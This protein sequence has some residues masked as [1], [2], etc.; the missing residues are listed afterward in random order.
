VRDAGVQAV[1]QAL[2]GVTQDPR[3]LDRLAGLCGDDSAAGGVAFDKA[4][5]ELTK[6]LGVGRV[7][8]KEIRKKALAAGGVARMA[9]RRQ[10]QA[11]GRVMIE[12]HPDQ[13]DQ[14][15]AEVRASLGRFDPPRVFRLGDV[16][17]VVQDSVDLA[18]QLAW[19]KRVVPAA[20][21]R[22]LDGVLLR[23]EIARVAM[24]YDVVRDRAVTPPGDIADNV[25]RTALEVPVPELVGLLSCPVLRRDGSIHWSRGYDTVT[26]VYVTEDFT[27]LQALVPEQ[28]TEKDARVSMAA[29]VAPFSEVPFA[30]GFG[31]SVL[32]AHILTLLIRHLVQVVVGF[33][34][35]AGAAGAGKGLV[36][37]AA[38]RI[39]LG[40]EPLLM[41]ALTGGGQSADEETRK[42]LF[43]C[44]L[45]GR[46]DVVIDN[47]LRGS[48]FGSP[49]LDALF[50][51]VEMSD[52]YLGMSRMAALPNR[53]VISFTGNN[54]RLV[55]DLGRRVLVAHIDPKCPNPEDRSGFAIPDLPAYLLAHRGTL[56]AHALTVMR[57]HLQ[58]NRP[59]DAGGGCAGAR[60]LG[61]FEEWSRV[62]AYAVERC[63]LINPLESQTWIR[64][65]I[66]G[67]REDA[68]LLETLLKA[69]HANYGAAPFTARELLDPLS[70]AKPEG[71]APEVGAQ[72]AAALLAGQRDELAELCR[73]FAPTY[74]SQDPVSAMAS[75]LRKHKGRSTAGG[76]ILRGRGLIHGRREYVVV[77]PGSLS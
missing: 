8:L 55:G 3:L 5:G 41:P 42:R 47:A 10:V 31:V 25:S 60:L 50:T 23:E 26:G 67:S 65:E 13:F 49:A 69:I 75:A 33:G 53:L 29:L 20:S 77:S 9:A 48:D 38:S 52:R 40:R 24:F 18:E 7:R 46:P 66:D 74:R 63:G 14:N 61:S 59:F 45:F 27:R 37:S 43:A 21:T 64:A 36:A 35:T 11:R 22:P 72:Q 71:G 16:L 1:R 6:E 51:A 68:A 15:C 57:W 54:L 12:L 56:L 70:A 62:V 2:A 73:S 19:A 44:L 17:V 76:W 30:H 34:Y 39:V 32:A 58:T 4:L 28:P